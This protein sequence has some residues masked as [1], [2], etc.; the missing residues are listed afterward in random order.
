MRRRSCRCCDYQGNEFS[1]T[2]YMI[3][4][5]HFRCSF[6]TKTLYGKYDDVVEMIFE[7]MVKEGRLTFSETLRRVAERAE[8]ADVEITLGEVCTVIGV[9]KVQGINPTVYI[10]S[11]NFTHHLFQVN[12]IKLFERTHQIRWS[13]WTRAVKF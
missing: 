3:T 8:R 11:V 7:E 5:F 6:I 9:G 10:S 13:K 12:I 2:L 4:P 1:L